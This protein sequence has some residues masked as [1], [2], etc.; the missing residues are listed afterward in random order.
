MTILAFLF[1][2]PWTLVGLVLAIISLPRGIRLN[3]KPFALIIAVHSFW[4]QTW[5][6][7]Y[8]GVR[9]SSIGA[10]VILGKKLLANDLEHELVH[11]TQYERE[12]FIHAFLYIYQSLKYG[13]KNNKYEVEAY[14]KAKNGYIEK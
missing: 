3:F 13:Y 14:A 12:P 4:W 7:G 2:L 10:V 11:V 6:P 1:N 8:G 5:L 9:A